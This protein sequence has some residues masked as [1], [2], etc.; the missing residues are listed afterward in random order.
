ML[1]ETG[2]CEADSTTGSQTSLE[3]IKRW[4]DDC[5]ENDPQCRGPKTPLLTRV[6]DVG[7]PEENRQP[8]LL[9]TMPGQGGDYLALSHCWGKPGLQKE[10]Q[11]WAT[12]P[13]KLL[14]LNEWP[15]TFQQAAR[16]TRVLMIRY[17][18]IDTACINQR[19]RLTSHAKPRR[20]QSTIPALL[21]LSP[22]FMP[23]IAERVVSSHATLYSFVRVRSDSRAVRARTFSLM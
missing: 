21:L 11:A 22:Q 14:P 16:N 4:L 13:Y 10:T 9:D 7:S 6:I 20:W 18:W 1:Y 19:T 17:L 3:L 15:Q 5:R 8:R 12:D 2:S 23:K